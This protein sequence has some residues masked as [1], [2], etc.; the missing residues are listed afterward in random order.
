MMGVGMCSDHYGTVVGERDKLLQQKTEAQHSYQKN[1]ER[2]REDNKKV[3]ERERERDR[4]KERERQRER[5][6]ERQ[7]ERLIHVHVGQFSS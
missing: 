6:R 4:E 3:R 5:E 2:G 7:R 1:M